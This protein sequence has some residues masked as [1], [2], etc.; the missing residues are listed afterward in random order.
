MRF[1]LSHDKHYQE[2]DELA[3]MA[4][5]HNT[6][7]FTFCECVACFLHGMRVH[8]PFTTEQSVAGWR[9]FPGGCFLGPARGATT[10]VVSRFAN[11][12]AESTAN[13]LFRGAR[14]RID[15]R[16]S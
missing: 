16:T 9:Q 13:P 11:E 15:G 6:S 2:A 14:E 8:S 3:N 4:C 1:G 7:V 5:I 10:A 12:G